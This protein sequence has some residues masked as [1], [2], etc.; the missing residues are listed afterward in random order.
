[1]CV[2]VCALALL[3]CVLL[4][5][6]INRL[7]LIICCVPLS[8]QL[9][10]HDPLRAHTSFPAANPSRATRTRPTSTQFPVCLCVRMY[11]CVC[12]CVCVHSHCCGACFWALKAIDSTLIICCVP[13]SPQLQT[14]DPLRA[15]TSFPAANPSR[16]T[17]T[18]P[19]STQFPVCMCV[20]MYVCV[21]VCVCALALLRCVLLGP[22]SN[23]LNLN[24]LLRSPLTTASDKECNTC[25]GSARIVCMHRI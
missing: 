14:H 6:E 13:L 21:C 4:G 9:Q 18:R 5:P 19:T 22:E 23:R 8:P 3:W 25:I 1:M 2:C 10:T 17:R 20:R 16:A 24:Y 11:V 7:N 12:V 15:H